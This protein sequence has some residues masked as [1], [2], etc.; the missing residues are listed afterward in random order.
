MLSLHVAVLWEGIFDFLRIWNRPF[1]GV[2][3]A[4]VAPETL[5]KGGGLRLPPFANP[6]MIDFRPLFL[7]NFVAIQ[8]AATCSLLVSCILFKSKFSSGV[9]PSFASASNACSYTVSVSIGTSSTGI[10]FP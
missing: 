8:S 7:Y 4:P 3:A 10:T 2:W 9:A 1:L 6:K 5:P